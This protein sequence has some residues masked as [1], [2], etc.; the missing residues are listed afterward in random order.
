MP[1]YKLTYFNV[2]SR[3]EPIRLMF[4]FAGVEYDDI[5]VGKEE[6]A[7]MKPAGREFTPH[8]VHFFT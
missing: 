6:W 8:F 5:R 2:R 4:A 1:T 7:K 3:A